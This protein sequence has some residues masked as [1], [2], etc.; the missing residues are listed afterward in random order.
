MLKQAVRILRDNA[1]KYTPAGGEVTFKAYARGEKVCFEVGDSGIG[2]PK[3]ELPRV[4]D[5]FYRGTNARTDNAGGSGLGLSIAQWIV[6]EHG[7]S[8]EAISSEGVGTKMTIVLD[9][10]QPED[11]QP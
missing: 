11:A 2:I 7:G 5:R 1:V 8:I 6:K 10:T 9:Q 4:F 3:D